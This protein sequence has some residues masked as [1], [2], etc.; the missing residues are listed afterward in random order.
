[1][2]AEEQAADKVRQEAEL[3]KA[4]TAG[5]IARNRAAL[6]A[7]R[8]DRARIESGQP[9]TA[10]EWQTKQRSGAPSS[11]PINASGARDRLGNRVLPGTNV[12]VNRYGIPIKERK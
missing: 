8:L 11:E 12:T 10:S 7:M 5:E 3:A 6:A 9:M 4:F 1:M 2:T